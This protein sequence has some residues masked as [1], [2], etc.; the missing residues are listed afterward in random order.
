MKII[1]RSEVF[2]GDISNLIYITNLSI[3]KHFICYI[4]ILCP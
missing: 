3:N 2:T 1:E 4:L